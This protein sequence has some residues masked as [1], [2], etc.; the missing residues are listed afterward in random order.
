VEV[1]DDFRAEIQRK[2]T[3]IASLEDEIDRLHRTLSRR[4]S[5]RKNRSQPSYYSI[6]NFYKHRFDNVHRRD[7][8]H[9]RTPSKNLHSEMH[10][11]GSRMQSD[12]E[13]ESS[14][15][16]ETYPPN[17]AHLFTEEVTEPSM[18][19]SAHLSSHM[20]G[21][22]RSTRDR[23]SMDTSHP[24]IAKL[25]VQ[26]N[27]EFRGDDVIWKAVRRTSDVDSCAMIGESLSDYEISSNELKEE[28]EEEEDES[29]YSDMEEETVRKWNRERTSGTGSPMVVY[30]EDKSDQSGLVAKL[31][32]LELD[33]VEDST[34][35]TSISEDEE[36]ESFSELEEES[37]KNYN[38]NSLSGPKKRFKQSPGE[39][40][41]KYVAPLEPPSIYSTPGRKE[42]EH[43][44][45]MKRKIESI[46]RSEE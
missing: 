27:G 19:F 29:S 30:I 20:T 3:Q 9:G 34:E 5:R 23:E 24:R 7:N 25:F 37:V 31:A 16:E 21:T 42:G 32:P 40:E 6:S 35:I 41:A 1:E 38:K 4:R 12:F 39:D 26:Q 10:N 28:E 36:E 22:P 17:P 15:D 45:Q 33:A 8:V 46:L 11:H 18:P 43:E 14:F 44:W 2:N 13:D